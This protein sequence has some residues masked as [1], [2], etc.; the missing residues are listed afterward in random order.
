MIPY[1]AIF[2]QKYRKKTKCLPLGKIILFFIEKSKKACRFKPLS[3]ILA[4]SGCHVNGTCGAKEPV[5]HA[6]L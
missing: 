1:Q 3:S 2:Q 6:H 4:P 5:M